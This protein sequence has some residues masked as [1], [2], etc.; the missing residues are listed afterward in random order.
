MTM[1]PIIFLFTA[2]LLMTLSSVAIRAADSIMAIPK[3]YFVT[4]IGKQ[5]LSDPSGA[6][7]T[8]Q[9]VAGKVVVAIFSA[10]TMSQGDAQQKWSD[11]LATN[12]A[13]KVSD[14]VVLV[15]VEDMTQAGIF[16]GVALDD[17]KKQ[18]APNERPF[19]ILDQTGDFFKRFG[20]PHGKTCVLIYDKK[21]RLRDV[22]VDLNDQATAT[23]RIKAIASK[24]LAG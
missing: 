7:H 22:E 3:G 4:S 16:K 5:A 24:L 8:Q 13:T 9:E 10:P 20:V 18:F 6:T 15:L 19:L 1:R 17:M 21:G 12:P 11:L 2:L 14:A 23:A